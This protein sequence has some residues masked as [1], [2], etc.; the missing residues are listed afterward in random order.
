MPKRHT[1][2]GREGTGEEFYSQNETE[3]SENIFSPGW[4]LEGISPTRFPHTWG[5]VFCKIT[6]SL[7][8]FWLIHCFSKPSTHTSF[9][10]MRRLMNLKRRQT[11][12]T[13]FK[14]IFPRLSYKS[15]WPH[16]ITG[17]RNSCAMLGEHAKNLLLASSSWFTSIFSGSPNIARGF[18]TPIKHRKCD[19]LCNWATA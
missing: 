12:I 10:I 6:T 18:L 5:H 8:G 14:T 15:K 16:F 3:T 17:V 4:T 1:Q 13:V 2:R 7:R 9:P 19:L 11:L